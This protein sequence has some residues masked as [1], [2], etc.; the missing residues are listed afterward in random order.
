MRQRG[1]ASFRPTTLE[2]EGV[3]YEVCLGSPG[4]ARVYRVTG[5]GVELERMRVA[6]DD[7][8]LSELVKRMPRPVGAKRE[9]RSLRGWVVWL[10]W[11]LVRKAR[12]W[13]RRWIW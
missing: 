5:K 12:Q 1:G 10:F 2:V 7:P 6:P 9:R 11:L 13:W 8:V 3:D 4:P